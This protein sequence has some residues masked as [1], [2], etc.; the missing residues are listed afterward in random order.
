M[1]IQ[2]MALGAWAVAMG[3]ERSEWIKSSQKENMRDDGEIS[4]G[5]LTFLA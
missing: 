1:I 3:L 2:A 5:L 4:Q